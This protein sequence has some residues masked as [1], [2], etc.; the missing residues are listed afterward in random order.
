MT[1][2]RICRRAALTAFVVA[3][4]PIAS[5][6]EIILDATSPIEEAKAATLLVPYAFYSPTYDFAIGF[7]GVLTGQIQ[8]QLSVFFN[9]IRSTNGT[10]QVQLGFYGAQIPGTNRLFADGWISAGRFA[11]LR[12][13]VG[14]D[15]NGVR[16]GSAGSDPDNFVRDEAIE[17]WSELRFDFVLPIGKGAKEP[18]QTYRLYRGILEGEGT[19]GRDW[20]PFT[21]GRTTL[22]ARP[23]YQR[24]DFE[25][26]VDGQ[27]IA[28]NGIELALEYDN[29]DFPRNPTYGSRQTIS[30]SRDFGAF[31]S[32]D[33]WTVVEGEAVKFID[34]GATSWSRQQVLAFGGWTA[35]SPTWNVEED[36]TITNAPP[37]YRGTTLGGRRRL[38][39]YPTDRFSDRA[40]LLYWLEYRMVP[41]WQP[42]LDVE[43]LAP[44]RIDWWQLALFTEVG[45]V[46]PSWSLEDLHSD[47]EWNV[48][49]SL[50]LFARK[51]IVRMDFAI[52][53]EGG[54]FWL[55]LGH[56]F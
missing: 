45:R 4:A 39:G 34:L 48:G 23:F 42:L 16:S 21:S 41:D 24:Q 29:T 19:G 3:A 2:P 31:D 14:E 11:E 36:G 37:Y 10:D 47:L 8:D 52:G 46:A 30:V 56:P 44:A 26:A 6:Q 20:N 53:P 49:A 50:R 7:G 33:D 38:R 40:A 25:K 35:Y 55:D 32:S 27:E 9:A 1:G 17:I 28:T 15:E 54:A 13:Y 43:E 5:A 22:S 18:I 51:A 12:A